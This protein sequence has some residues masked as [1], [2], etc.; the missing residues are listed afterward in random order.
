MQKYLDNGFTAEAEEK[1]AGFK[2]RFP[3]EKLALLIEAWTQMGKGQLEEALS[4]TNRYLETDTENAG[5]WRLRGR[6]L[7]AH[8]SAAKS[9]QRLAAQQTHFAESDGSS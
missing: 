5:A 9:D 8:E 7:P 3:E 4:L 2:E 6:L 1:L